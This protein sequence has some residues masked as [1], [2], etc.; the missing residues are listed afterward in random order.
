M[1]K[2]S[3]LLKKA[4][5]AVCHKMRREGG[6]K[7]AEVNKFD[8]YVICGTVNEFHIAG[9]QCSILKAILPILKNRIMHRDVQEPCDIIRKL[10]FRKKKSRDSQKILIELLCFLELWLSRL[11]ILRI[12]GNRVGQ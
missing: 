9:C 3:T 4:N 11:R 7:Q 6:S 10:D 2:C 5:H 1:R 12:T 8:K